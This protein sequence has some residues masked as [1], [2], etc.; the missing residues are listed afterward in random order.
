[1]ADA[2]VP[3]REGGG[4]PGD[5]G[6]G[7]DASDSKAA[8]D[9][10]RG[11]GAGALLGWLFLLP[12][13]VVLAVLVAYPIVWSLVRS[14]YGA[15]GWSDFTGLHN[16]K[17]LFTDD[18]TFTALKNNLIWVLVVPA[19][20]T[21]LGLVFAVLTE[22]V[23]FATAFKL[24]LFMPMAVSMLA[25]GIIF[26]L[27]YDH[28]PDKGVANAVVVGVHDAFSE[29]APY[30]GARP[31]GN[32]GFDA[33]GGGFVTKA[34]T[35]AGGTALLPLVA[36]TADKVPS[37]AQ[38][39]PLAPPAPGAGVSGVVWLDF[40]PG[41]AGTPGQVDRGEKGLPG[42]KIEAVRG[43]HTVGSATTRAD[44]SFTLPA[45]ATKGGPV[46]LRLA[47][48]NFATSFGGYDWLGP[49]LITP[50]IIGA[51]VW[52]WAGFAMVLIAAG[53]AAIPRDAL[54]AARVDGATEWQVF[55][56]VTVPLLAP[57]LAVV[58]VTLVINVL[59]VFDLVYIVSLGSSQKEANVLALQMYLASFGG[60]N[61][62]GLG[63]AI[64]IVLFLLVLPA[65]LFNIRR[66]RRENR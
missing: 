63:S 45:S 14:L 62:Q 16:Y 36:L 8:G 19:V 38:P 32:A 9:Q 2:A 3:A 24:I 10:P 53:L 31:R 52:M 7:T 22:R 34:A 15:D 11:P 43:G 5:A 49:S 1:M 61:N 26:R 25:A 27:V 35:P 37:D 39:A 65:M 64:G 28:D 50:A 47:E 23:R 51:Y 12:A 60:G 40:S 55:R 6:P 44:G 21:A 66:F 18:D 30:P 46:Q 13:L 57:V 42:V 17:E 59:K 41:N 20:V 58:M 54:E 29:G 4:A 33:A 56:R 48:S